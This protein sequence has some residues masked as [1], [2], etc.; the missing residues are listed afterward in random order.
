[1]IGRRF[2]DDQTPGA[3]V[4]VSHAFAQAHFGSAAQ[5]V[6]RTVRL[7]MTPYEVVGV[8]PTGFSFPDATEIW[9][10]MPPFPNRGNTSFLAVGRLKHGHSIEQAQGEVASIAAGLE[11]QYLTNRGRGVAVSRLHDRMV[12]NVRLMLHLLLGAVAIVLLMACANL[13]T[14]FLARATARTQEMAIRA[15]LGAS[16]GRILRQTIAEGM[17]L[18]LLAGA[19]GLLLAWEGTRALVAIAP[20][21][22]P[23]LAEVSVDRTVLF[24]TLAVSGAS[25]FLVALAPAF[26]AWH[27]DV[28]SG[29]RHG[30]SRATA[31]GGTRRLRD[32][33]VVGQL[34]MAV[35]LLA[36]GT[37][38][39]KSFVALQHT[40]LGV[41]PENVLVMDASVATS[42]PNANAS[43]FFRDLLAD[44]S[45]LP[46][47][48]AAGATMSPPGR[49]DSRGGYAIDHP[50]A[51]V[52]SPDRRHAVLSI[53][54]PGAFAALGIPLVRGRDF[55]DGDR[56]GAPLVAI[57]NETLV[58]Q[59]PG[60][61][62]PLGRSVYCTFDSHAPMRIVGVVGDVRQ[63][64]PANASQPECYMPYL[65][66][67]Y[68]DNTLRLVVRTAADP[69]LLAETLRRKAHELS[70]AVPVKF[71]TLETLLAQHVASPRFRALLIGV[72]ATVAL[73]L[74]VVGLFGIMAYTVAQRTREIGLRLALGAGRRTVVWL[75]VDQGCG[76][77]RPD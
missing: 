49:V 27:A 4:L 31:A 41:R 69:V 70:P 63:S 38:L 68:N 56:Q 43:L 75:V 73:L 72:F 71:T 26:Q 60:D 15:A 17:M 8:L 66:H 74:A 29:V 16:R 30:L 5:A 12:A 44:V 59:A 28:E 62:D 34:A 25:S 76:S 6:G 42:D 65:Q 1:M 77:R 50:P 24:F 51:D 53:V 33:L 54:S 46:G 52:G 11:Q 23:R 58:R 57:V 35:V 36:I 2:T 64:G 10:R 39:M 21:D 47:V 55:D 48:L 3:E 37:L 45:L 18:G 13:A 61:R 9:Q 67:G 20:G 19:A 7:R 14:L 22:V 40:P 32:A